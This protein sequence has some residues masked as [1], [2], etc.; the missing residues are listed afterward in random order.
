MKR[1]TF[2]SSFL[3]I[4]FS[5]RLAFSK[6]SWPYV[7]ALA[8]P[9]LL[10][11]GQRCMTRMANRGKIRRSLSSYYRFLSDGKWRMTVLFRSLFDLVVQTFNL[12]K[13]ILL[14]VDDTL[15]PKWGREIFGTAS[16]FDHVRRPRAGY[17]WGHN[18]IVLALVVP[19]G[20]AGWMS[21]PFWIALYRCKKSCPKGVFRTRHQLVA[22][23]L[24]MVRTWYSGSI[25]LLGDGAYNNQSII[26]P[27]RKL[28]IHLI[29]RMRSDARLRGLYPKPPKKGKRGAKP[30][31]G[32]WLPK[33]KDMIKAGRA[34][35]TE[36]VAIYGKTVTLRVRTFVAYWPKAGCPIRVVITRDPNR[37]KRVAIL[38]CTNI[39][40]TPIQIIEDFSRRWSIEQL[41]SVAKNQMGLDT[42]EV[43]KECSVLRHAALCMA[44]ATW[45]PVWAFRLRPH[46][47]KSSFAAQLSALREETIKE[48]IFASGPRTQG[49]RRIAQT[50]GN[51]FAAVTIS[52]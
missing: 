50:L 32:P 6:R 10:C 52:A 24:E 34:F 37:K 38:S 4:V 47:G 33:L 44:L 25:R 5:A 46:L 9:W 15:C 2:S 7:L 30:T 14:V 29:G 42:A 35:Q 51:L 3:G 39:A 18:W 1:L 48:T 36:R 41:F 19:M 40:Q 26:R 27:A 11:A 12:H 16:F 43:R 20:R 13:E 45:V 31:W 23:A 8:L 17:I 21:L 28:G 49:S 22:T